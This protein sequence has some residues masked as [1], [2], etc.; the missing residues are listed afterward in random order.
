PLEAIGVS[1]AFFNVRGSGSSDSGDRILI[2][3]ANRLGRRADD[4]APRREGLALRDERT[5][6]DHAI[7]PDHSVVED[8][9][10]H[11]D[12]DTIAQ[13]AAVEHRVMADRT[14]LPNG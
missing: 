6:A 9:R 13:G 11:A 4:Q 3:V 2:K 10:T 14:S 1:T 7:I 12:Q 5:G 8:R